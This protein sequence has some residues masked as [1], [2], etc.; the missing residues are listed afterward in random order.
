M[1]HFGYKL[2]TDLRILTLL[3]KDL[4]FKILNIILAFELYM[5]FNIGL[6]TCTLLY[7]N[8]SVGMNIKTVFSKVIT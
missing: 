5:Y 1:F 7:Q 4:S 3:V 6:S 2:A 8:C